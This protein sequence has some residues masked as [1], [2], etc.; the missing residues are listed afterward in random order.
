MEM[1]PTLSIRQALGKL[2]PFGIKKEFVGHY[3]KEFELYINDCRFNTCTRHHEPGCAII[4][5]VETGGI[6]E[7]GT[8]AIRGY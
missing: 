8:K 1:I 4:R 5:A 2:D 3:F 7:E 6:S